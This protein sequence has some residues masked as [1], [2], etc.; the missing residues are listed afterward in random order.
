ML[1]RVERSL[2]NGAYTSYSIVFGVLEKLTSP[3][4]L[5][6]NFEANPKQLSL[7]QS[8]WNLRIHTVKNI[9]KGSK[10]SQGLPTDS[11]F[12]FPR[13]STS[14][15]AGTCGVPTHPN[16]TGRHRQTLRIHRP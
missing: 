16:Q 10:N 6:I 4:T 5:K 8:F 1:L 2:F 13:I 11:V 7:G 9:S 3:E 14:I 15:I 12:G